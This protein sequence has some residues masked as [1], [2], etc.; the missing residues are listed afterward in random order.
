DV[1]SWTASFSSGGALSSLVDLGVA[2]GSQPVTWLVD[3]AVIDAARRLADGNPP[4]SL[5]STVTAENGNGDGG[6]GSES[7][8]PSA[9]PTE[10]E[11]AEQG[12]EKEL[13]PQTAAAAEAAAGWLDRLHEGL[14]GKQILALPY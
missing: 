6:D 9:S 14:E 11:G 5:A 13:D 8:S 12:E 7:P 4:R 2:S 3:P 10:G 1:D